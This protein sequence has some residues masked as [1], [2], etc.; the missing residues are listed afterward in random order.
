MRIIK[1]T[2]SVTVALLTTLG[3]LYLRVPDLP[4]G[5]T[6][7]IV[8]MFAHDFLYDVDREDALKKEEP[9]P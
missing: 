3:L 8:Y 9:K 7:G 5:F 6:G 1:T 4:A 2:I